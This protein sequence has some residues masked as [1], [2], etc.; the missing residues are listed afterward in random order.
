M[1]GCRILFHRDFQFYTGGHGKVWDYFCHAVNLGLDARVYLTPDSKRDASNP[2]MGVPDRLVDQWAPRQF[3]VVFLA[4]MDWQAFSGRSSP[5][6]VIN[7]IQGTRHGRADS[8]LR[9]FLSRSAHRIC[10]S[11]AVAKAIALTGVVNGPSSVISPAVDVVPLTGA[12]ALRSG[13]LISGMK[14]PALAQDA[15]HTLRNMGYEVRVMDQLMPRKAYLEAVAGARV[16]VALPL[17]QEGFYLP[18]LE[19][20]AL[21]V[22]VVTTDCGGNRDYAQDGYNCMVVEPHSASI[23]GAVVSLMD[24][25]V[26]GRMVAGGLATAAKHTMADEQAQFSQVLKQVLS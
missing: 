2:W 13:V 5:R 9:E 3:D 16:F 25:G 26:Q 4:G 19:G 23:V 12:E 7:L 15:A 24:A 18:A 6:P 17:P 8:P 1:K 20:M 10:V 21:G 14:A 22:P 11:R